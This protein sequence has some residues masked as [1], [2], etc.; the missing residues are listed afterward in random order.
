MRVGLA[1]DIMIYNI[2]ISL[3]LCTSTVKRVRVQQYNAY[4]HSLQSSH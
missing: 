1:E 3:M 2:M 4:M